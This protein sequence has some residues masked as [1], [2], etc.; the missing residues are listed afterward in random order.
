M[1]NKLT[2]TSMMVE[3]GAVLS[4]RPDQAIRVN[5]V[6]GCLWLTQSGVAGDTFLRSGQE[7][8][9]QAGGLVVIESLGDAPAHLHL[10]TEPGLA[11]RLRSDLAQ[12]LRSV[13]RYVEQSGST[14]AITH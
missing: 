10:E 2:N 6:D 9:L 8:R 12:A 7:I 1:T 3:Q 5:C 14:Q 11:M 4:M 13:A